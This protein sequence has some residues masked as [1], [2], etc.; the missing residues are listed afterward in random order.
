MV[1]SFEKILNP[2]QTPNVLKRISSTSKTPILV[3]YCNAST[4]MMNDKKV[5][6]NGLK[7]LNFGKTH[8][9]KPNGTNI[10][11]FPKTLTKNIGHW[12]QTKL[13]SPNLIV[14]TKGTIRTIFPSNCVLPKP[15]NMKYRSIMT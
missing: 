8:P 3:K 7:C 9:K 10:K 11:I 13:L 12:L 1:F 15:K 6:N 2:S 14:E 5:N 4:M